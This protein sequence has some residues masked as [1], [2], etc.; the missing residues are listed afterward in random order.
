MRPGAS[1]ERAIPL[2]ASPSQ[3]TGTVDANG[4]RARRA[5]RVEPGLR[6]RGGRRRHAQPGLDDAAP[7]LVR[8]DPVGERRR[9]ASRRERRDGTPA[10]CRG[11]GRRS[12]RARP[13]GRRAW[14]P[15]GPRPAPRAAARPRARAR[16]RRSG[17]RARRRR[18]RA[19]WSSRAGRPCRPAA[20]RRRRATGRA[21]AP[22]ARA[23]RRASGRVS[24]ARCRRRAA[25]PGRCPPRL[26][27]AHPHVQTLASC[28]SLDTCLAARPSHLTTSSQRESGCSPSRPPACGVELKVS[29][30][31]SRLVGMPIWIRL[32]SRERRVARMRRL[33]AT[34]PC[35][36]TDGPGEV[37]LRDEVCDLGDVAPPLVRD[38]VA[39]VGPVREQQERARAALGEPLQVRR[40]RW[41]GTARWSPSTASASARRRARSRRS[42]G[43]RSRTT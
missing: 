6:L 25:C 34:A 22:R 14:R 35:C 13:A 28:S 42:A 8:Q 17:A 15:G 24:R 18:R 33:P 1:C 2:R 37:R 3:S 7:Q 32:S 4:T 43:G 40:A 10:D 16:G 5:V 29:I 30:T 9:H 38:L 36:E 12:R 19:A 20:P 26:K 11:S 21:A 27:A 23:R 39:R 31:P 41:R